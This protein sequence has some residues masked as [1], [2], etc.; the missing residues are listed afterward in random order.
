M[1]LVENQQRSRDSLLRLDESETEMRTTIDIDD[2]LMAAAMKCSGVPT[3][4]GT[5]EEALRILV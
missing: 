3:K 1:A 4:K 2:D 5:V